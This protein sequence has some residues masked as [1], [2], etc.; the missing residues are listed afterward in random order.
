MA[1]LTLTIPDD[2]DTETIAR[3]L[4][5]AALSTEQRRGVDHPYSRALRAIAPA[6]RPSVTGSP[7]SEPSPGWARVH[8]RQSLPDSARCRVTDAE[9]R[10]DLGISMMGNIFM[11][12]G[13]EDAQGAHVHI[14]ALRDRVHPHVSLDDCRSLDLVV[15][16][17]LDSASP[18]AASRP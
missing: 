17:L 6:A 11:D 8:G 9:S 16:V 13:H 5:S 3:A 2:L 4:A 18:D 1:E 14:P 7:A 12:A 15:D 10:S